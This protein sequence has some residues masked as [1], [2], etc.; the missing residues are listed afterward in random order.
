[1]ADDAGAEQLGEHDRDLVLGPIAAEP[2]CDVRGP[3]AAAS[4]ELTHDLGEHRRPP[5]NFPPPS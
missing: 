3:A 4:L 1:M 2:A 5:L